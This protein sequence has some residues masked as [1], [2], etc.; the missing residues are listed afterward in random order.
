MIISVIVRKKVHMNMRLVL[1]GYRDTTVCTFKYKNI[2]DGNEEIEIT[3][4]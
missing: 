1:C 3:S 4:C 2:V